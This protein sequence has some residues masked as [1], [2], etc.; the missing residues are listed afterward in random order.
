MKNFLTHLAGLRG[1]AILFIILFH[2]NGELFHEGYLGVD[3]FLVISGYLLFIGNQKA[4]SSPWDF[5]RRKVIRIVP[6]LS[7]LVLLAL[8]A[9]CF[10]L[11][12]EET[13]ETAA[14]TGLSA[15]LGYSNVY[16]QEITTDYFA[17][18]ANLNPFLHTWYL[19]LTIQVY[20]LWCVCTWCFKK[21]PVRAMGIFLTLVALT[22][23]MY[24]HSYQIQGILI[25]CGLNGW[26]QIENVSYFET[27]GRLWEIL[28]GGLVLLLPAAK[29][30][31][32]TFC[33]ILSSLIL[34]AALTFGAEMG[35][36]LA[37]ILTVLSTVLL[38]KYVPETPFEKV[39]S[40]KSLLWFGKI[41][42]SWYL[43]HF[44]LF[45]LTKISTGGDISLILYCTL[46]VGSALAAWFFWLL[47][48]K[49]KFSLLVSLIIWSISVGFTYMA[50]CTPWVERMIFDDTEP[51]YPVY[52]R[53]IPEVDKSLFDGFDK[54]TLLLSRGIMGCLV[55]D[56]VD[57]PDLMPLGDPSKQASF[58]V[59]GDS[60]A[61][62]LYSGINELSHSAGVSG[63]QVASIILPFWNRYVRVGGN[64]YMYNRE[65]GEAFMSWL[66][67]HPELKTV[68]I[69]QLWD[70]RMKTTDL[71]WDKNL[72]KPSYE[73][74]ELCLIEFCER[75]K[76]MGKQVV[77]ITPT[78]VI[79]FDSKRFSSGLAYMRWR[80]KQPR[81]Y[82]DEAKNILTKAQ[83][84]EQN[85]QVFDL[86]S[87]LE[88]KGICKVLHMEK[89]MFPDGEFRICRGKNLY[90][91]DN[92]HI[93]PL[94][95]IELFREIRKEFIGLLNQS[96]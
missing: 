44:P 61:Q 10:I 91:K 75:I 38:L 30:R 87:R 65:K 32:R 4:A 5:F 72:I 34:I 50:A 42:F 45:V 20:I 33:V 8:L 19:S 68:F 73:E 47:I 55:N 77:L 24:A 69:G 18:A 88:Q 25:A 93:T 3:I 83:Y 11:N 15:L 7:A 58:V 81:D 54:K 62:H 96:K 82:Q 66:S 13:I 57:G 84:H 92:T 31:N 43:I 79:R 48:E 21:L 12:T 37:V 59:V 85:K 46:F 6:S 70:S 35:G 76:A 64:I 74:N 51:Q 27:A 78:P 36:Q 14:L 23:F 2:L 90:M 9:C 52:K 28:A 89:G 63:V 1:A 26:G 60:N 49:Q 22:S 67:L 16:L 86:F 53:E 41:S 17:A 95:A 80:C 29:Q 40:N 39:F 56:L 94:A 71:D